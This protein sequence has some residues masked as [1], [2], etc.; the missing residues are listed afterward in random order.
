[1]S[2]IRMAVSELRRITAGRLPVLAVLALLL[3]PMLYAGFYLY[4]NGDPY[5]RL[6]RVP[7]ALVVEDAGGTDADGD[8]QNVGE[9]VARNLEESG[10]FD[11][12]RVSAADADR[13][14]RDSSYTFAL[15]L[16]RDFTA[17]LRSSADLAPRQGVMVLTTNDA[18]NYLVRTIADTLTTKVR[19]SVA[20]QVG[21]EAADTFLTGFSTIYAKTQEAANGAGELASGAT[22][23]HDGAAQLASGADELA[24]GQ[25]RLLGGAQQLSGGAGELAT[26]AGTLAGGAGTAAAGADRLGAGAGELATGLGTLRDATAELPQQ[27]RRLAGGARQV[28]DGNA[29]LADA[30]DRVAQESARLAA[31][32]DA[33][34]GA[35][36]AALR[37]RGFTEEQVQQA[38]A[39]LATAKQPLQQGNE[40]VQQV[41]GQLDRLGSG[42]RQVADGAEQLAGSAPQLSSGIASA[43]DGAGTLR[44][45]AS[46]LSGG[47]RRLADGATQLSTGAT[48]LRTG[49]QQLTDGERTAVEGTDRLAAGAHQLDSG[50]GELADGA[51]RLRDGLA[52]G[53]GQIP[54]PEPGVRDATARTIGD[55]VATRDVAYTQA[56]TY[57]AGL[58]PFFMALATWIGGYVLFL[59]VQPLSRRAIAAGQSPLR[60][61]LGG[62][63]PAG[64]LGVAQVTGMYAVVVFALGITPVHPLATYGFLCLVS[65][66]FTAIVHALNAWLG[67][68][69]QFLGLVLMVL[70]LVSAGGTFP[71]QTIPEPLYPVHYLM[72]MGYAVDALRHLMYGGELAGVVGTAVP[73]LAGW[74]ALAVLVATL[75]ARRQRVWTPATVKPELVL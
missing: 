75:A 34:D 50:T 57:G 43:A 33:A 11:F 1:M 4:A 64:L 49:A 66:V 65:V 73:V 38:L 31:D 28:A 30:G 70:Q 60:V 59:L 71:W 35:I 48:A 23:A 41:S 55:P 61:A 10:S 36:A 3:V 6:D 46:E 18:N 67:S 32:L 68:V 44:D 17:A 13:G 56:D 20:Q 16:P 69:G 74:F 37:E 52:D 39:A 21:T 54:N 2:A 47:V 72:P 8:P 12:H 29:Q 51:G 27:S 62:W 40:R 45:G 42:A 19:Q 53:L 7:A 25:R 58:A 26:G 15:T 63:I 5:S 22:R 14:V 24:S 9:E